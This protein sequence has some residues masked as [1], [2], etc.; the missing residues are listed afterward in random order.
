VYRLDNFSFFEPLDVRFL[1]IT[2][3]WAKKA[4]VVYV[5]HYWVGQFFAYLTWTPDLDAAPY[6]TLTEQANQAISR[7]F[8]AGELTALGHTWPSVISK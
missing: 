6:R 8:L 2:A 5:S 7:A 4:G 3:Q 1:T